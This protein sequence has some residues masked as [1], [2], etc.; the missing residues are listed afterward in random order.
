MARAADL[1]EVMRRLGA[2]RPRTGAVAGNAFELYGPRSE[3]VRDL[4]GL[5][6]GEHV[7]EVLNA[8]RHRKGSSLT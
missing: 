6:I 7:E 8:T 3:I 2:E 4:Y 5:L 1:V